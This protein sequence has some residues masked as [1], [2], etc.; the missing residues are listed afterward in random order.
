MMIR[1]ILFS[2]LLSCCVSCGQPGGNTQ[3]TTVTDTVFVQGPQSVAGHTDTLVVKT[4]APQGAETSTE[5]DEVSMD[6]LIVPGESIGK[7]PLGMDAQNI[8]TVLGKPDRSDAAMGKAWLTWYGKGRDEHNN[9]TELDIYTTYRDNSMREKT[10]Q[11]IR[12][13]SSFFKTS[14]GVGVYNSLDEIK[15][16]FPALKQVARYKDDGRTIRIYDDVGK[17]ISFDIAEAGKQLICVGVTVHLK[18]KPVAQ[19][20][21]YLHPGTE[22]L[23]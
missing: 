14:G 12:V 8:E 15:R 11:Q 5:K 19:T 4:R 10:V 22:L 16:F 9:K 2:L 7:T 21:I 18:G 1:F 3:E 20:Y 6:R 17:G 13:T 23:P